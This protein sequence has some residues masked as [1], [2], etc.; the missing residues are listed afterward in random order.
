VGEHDVEG[1]QPRVAERQRHA[2]RLAAQLDRD[3]REHPA[4]GEHKRQPVARR[5]DAHR[6][7]H[8]HRQELNRG[9][10][11]ERQPCDPLVEA[12][13]HD[14]EHD[15]ERGHQTHRVA[16]GPAQR[17]PRSAPQRE[18]DR[19]ADDPQP[20]DA[21]RSDPHEQQHRE[22][23]SEVVEDG[24]SDEIRLGRD[25][26]GASTRG[27]VRIVATSAALEH[28]QMK[29]LWSF[30]LMNNGKPTAGANDFPQ[31][32]SIDHRIINELS[33]DGRVS[34]AEL[35]R[36]TNLSSPAVT[37]RVKRLEQAGVITGYR[38][39]VDPRALGYQLT[40]IVRV[41]PAVRQLRKIAELA[42]EIR[43]V[44]ECLRITGEDCFYIKLHLGSIEELP[45]IL[46]RFL[47][48]G[49]TTTSIVNATPVARRDPPPHSA[50]D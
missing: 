44:E 30:D 31:L 41:K 1:E 9:H 39:E 27:H 21:E 47:L 16:I 6:R 43:E 7:E 22:R 37:E 2:E 12:A 48:Y 50:L 8:D 4:H 33:T 40:A 38:A 32:D 24:T 3:E 45:S 13:V 17:P 26:L 34:F 10:S 42:A 28:G 46:D 23:G 15:P 18:H 36:R 19:G 25:V 49:E 20:G 11:P 14:R 29:V 5:A 35:G